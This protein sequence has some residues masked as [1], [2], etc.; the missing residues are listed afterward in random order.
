MTQLVGP[1]PTLRE[2]GAEDLAAVHAFAG[3]PVATRSTS[4]GPN[5]PRGELGDLRDHLLARARSR[6]SLH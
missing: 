2:F 1:R 6:D 5:T 3:D 4:S